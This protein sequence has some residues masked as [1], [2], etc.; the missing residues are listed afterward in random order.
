M[1]TK[2]AKKG[3]TIDGPTA[4]DACDKFN[5]EFP[6]G[7]VVEYWSTIPFGPKR[8]TKVRGEAFVAASGDEVCFVAGVAGYVSIWH[9]RA[10]ETAQ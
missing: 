1:T 6:V 7:T 3:R 10:V 8:E 9:V 2:R 5:R 4:Q